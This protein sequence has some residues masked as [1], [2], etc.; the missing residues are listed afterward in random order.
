VYRGADALK[1]GLVDK[2]GSLQDAVNHAAK[3]AQSGQG[4]G[5]SAS[6]FTQNFN[7]AWQANSLAS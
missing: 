2:I 7:S 3:L 6:L 1:H 4:G 5:S